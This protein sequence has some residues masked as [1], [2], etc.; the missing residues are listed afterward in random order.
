MRESAPKAKAAAQNAG[1][2]SPVSNQEFGFAQLE[3]EKKGVSSYI[4][5]GSCSAILDVSFQR[6]LKKNVTSGTVASDETLELWN[7]E[8]DGK[9]DF[10]QYRSRL[11]L[12][13]FYFIT[14]M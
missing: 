11:V 1:N 4:D 3:N 9:S 13:V 12:L 8:F 14:S 5:D 7:D 10:S 6:M 2:N